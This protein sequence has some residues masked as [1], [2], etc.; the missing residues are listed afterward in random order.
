MRMIITRGLGLIIVCF[1]LVGCGTTKKEAEK[2]KIYLYIAGNTPKVIVKEGEGNFQLLRGT[3]VELVSENEDNYIV[4]YNDKEYTVNKEN[5]SKDDK[6]IVLEKELFVRTP[7]TVY[8]DSES[9]SILGLF[10]KG[11]K[12]EIL[13]YDKIDETG[14]VN[15]YKVKYNDKE[16]YIYR[17]YLVGTL[18]EANK[19]YDYNGSN[20]VHA[21]MG[22]NL[23][24]GKATEL[25][26]YPYEKGKFE[27]NVMPAE[28]RTLYINSA[29]I[30]D[31]DKYVEL[32][33]EININAFVVDIK[34]NTS[35][36]YPAKAMEKYSPTNYQKAINTYDEYKGYIKKLKDNG[37]YVIG[38]I[39]VFKDSYFVKD[40]PE[41]AIK[42][43]NGKAL[44]HNGSN[45]PSAYN[46]Y[47][48]EFNVE[49]AKESIKEIGFNEIQFDYVRFPDRTRALE[50]NKKIN[51]SNTYN[52]SKA[53]ALQ[54]FA[55]YA[56][57]EIHKLN[58]Y[59]S[60][61]VFGESVH[62]YV[63]A[64]GQ[65]WPALS[66]IVDVI[67]GMPYPDHFDAYQYGFKEVTWTVPYKLLNHWSSLVVEKQKLV[68]TPA[69][70]R[71]WIQAYD[72]TWKTP[73]VVY[74]A[75]K[76]SDEIK[77]LKDNNICDG[78]MTWNSGSSISKYRSIGAAFRKE[79][80]NE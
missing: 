77:A 46:R 38:R 72:T 47:V 50:L 10:K 30:K 42:D 59:V 66:N 43:N 36:A 52:E 79:Y 56:A 54:M 31:A 21:K 55:M 74:D 80:K 68:P 14:E 1:L 6:N 37:F 40:H 62:D 23:G 70:V 61:D 27:D 57:D 8:M 17:K 63:T 22:S 69:K 65:Y 60:I 4:K 2:E 7:V 9:S 71:T 76:V 39:T 73:T 75:D 15:K 35:P 53:Q 20:A 26:Y 32:A 3:K 19:I 67:S 33:K 29:A 41:T 34:D 16:G 18:E 64:Y 12:I 58:A 28:T 13:G 24:G 48:W 5:I 49:L 78:Y 51:Y 25:D 44:N 45:W 11:T